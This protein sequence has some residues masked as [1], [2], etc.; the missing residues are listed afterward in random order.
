[1]LL[2]AVGQPGFFFGPAPFQLLAA[3]AGD[4][5]NEDGTDHEQ[6]GNRNVS[7]G[8]F[9]ILKNENLVEPFIEPNLP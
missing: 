4:D 9:P 1:M 8:R 2:D 7:H 5:A 3:L 6:A